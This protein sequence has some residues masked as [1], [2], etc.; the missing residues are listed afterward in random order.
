MTVK[1]VHKCL[2]AQNALSLMFMKWSLINNSSILLEENIRQRG[3]IDKLISDSSK[4]EIS[5]R[6]KEILRA[7]F[8]D[9]WQSEACHQHQ[10]FSE[11][12]FQTIKKHTNTLLNRTGAHTH[13]WL[14]AMMHVFFVLNHTY[15]V[16]IKNTPFNTAIG[17]TCDI[18]PMLRFYFWQLVYFN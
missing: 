10:N 9:Y 2:L 4:S 18:S 7:L 11:R 14:L 3:E 16:T 5:L 8:I 15:N 17:S 6:L 12:R 13:T 1:S